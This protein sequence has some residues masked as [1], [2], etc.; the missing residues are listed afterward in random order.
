MN[1]WSFNTLI[2]ELKKSGLSSTKLGTLRSTLAGAGSIWATQVAEIIK[3]L[4][5]DSDQ[6]EVAKMAYEYA[7]D[8]GAY[9]ARTL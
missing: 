4:S 2:S 1:L 9:A 3:L 6:L 7:K 8:K 5:F